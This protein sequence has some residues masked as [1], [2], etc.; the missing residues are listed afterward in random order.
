MST[1]TRRRGD[2]YADEINVTSATTG[3]PIPITGYSFIMT[4]DPEKAP[5]T[6][7][8]N[9]YQITGEII[10]D[11]TAGRVEFAPTPLQAD[12]T[13]GTYYFDI[14]MVDG[15]GRKRTIALDKYVYTQDITK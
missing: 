6:A 3:E 8:N 10:G 11:G 14:Q 2:T 5:A 7:A 13:P 12:Q 4:L 1:I 15:A 9:L